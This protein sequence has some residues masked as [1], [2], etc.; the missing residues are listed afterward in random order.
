[1]GIDQRPSAPRPR[2][3]A[4][5]TR[6]FLHWRTHVLIVE[7]V[8]FDESIASGIPSP[9]PKGSW[10]YTALSGIVL[11]DTAPVL[12]RVR[13]RETADRADEAEQDVAM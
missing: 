13:Q 5:T 2:C 7:I 4:T 11:L 12:H 9:Y 1:M 8:V 6:S 10:Y 3:C